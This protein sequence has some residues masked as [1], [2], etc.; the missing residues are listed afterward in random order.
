M[1]TTSMF[2]NFTLVG[3]ININL[4]QYMSLMLL[5]ENGLVD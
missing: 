4:I 2:V 1:N 3:R 5:T